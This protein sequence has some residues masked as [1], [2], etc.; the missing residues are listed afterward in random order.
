MQIFLSYASEQKAEAEAISFAL[1]KRGHKVFLDKDDLPPGRSYDDQIQ[2][3]VFA[4]DLMIFLITPESVT[5]GRYTLTELEYAR[6]RWRQPDRNILPVMLR[7]TEMS[8][9]PG[10]L[11]AVTIQE[12][13]GNL[14]AEVAFWVDQ[15]RGRDYI[16]RMVGWFALGGLVAGLAY[17]G[18]KEGWFGFPDIPY[19]Q[20]VGNTLE[21]LFKLVGWNFGRISDKSDIVLPI[22]A[23]GALFPAGIV[24]FLLGRFLLKVPWPRSAAAAGLVA[25][26][27]GASVLIGAEAYNRMDAPYNEIRRLANELKSARNELAQLRAITSLNKTKPSDSRTAPAVPPEDEVDDRTPALDRAMALEWGTIRLRVALLYGLLFGLG[28]LAAGSVLG[29]ALHSTRR[30]GLSLVASMALA[31]TLYAATNSLS[32]SFLL[33]HVGIFA[34]IGYWIARGQE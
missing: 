33:Y 25:T 11:K 7:T 8:R 29:S 2:R 14:A 28:M 32:V 23:V 13:R 18:S 22:L 17:L 6:H 24:T 16:L 31:G 10:F 1:R 27:T 3:A 15:L 19:A 5:P 20:S 26:M 34:L 4:A 30:W 21:R 9:V 12:Q